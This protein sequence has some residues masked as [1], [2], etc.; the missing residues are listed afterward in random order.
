M[1]EREDF[2][3]RFQEEKPIAMHE[4]L[5]PLAQGYDSVA[6]E[7]DVE[8]GGTDQKF[9]LLVG[10]EL[11]RTY[12]QESQVV[13][14]TPI[15]EGLDGVKKMSKSLGNA[16]GIHE[17]PL[18]M[19]G[20]IMSISDDMMWRYYELLTDV[21]V[22]EIEALKKR[23]H[24][25]ES[26]KDL[27]WKIVRDFHASQAADAAMQDWTRQFQFKQTPDAIPQVEV[28]YEEIASGW[29]PG[30]EILQEAPIKVDKLVYKAGLAASITEASKKRAGRAVKNRRRSC[31]GT[32]L[33]FWV[34]DISE[35]SDPSCRTRA[36][37]GSYSWAVGPL[38]V[39]LSE[40]RISAERSSRAVEGSL[41]RPHYTLAEKAFSPLEQEELPD[42]ACAHAESLGIFRLRVVFASERQHFAQDDNASGQP[43]AAVPT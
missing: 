22:A 29:S 26:K 33:C 3:K 28:N 35:D 6:L 43:R 15:L 31:N 21:Q 17:P 12:G 19:Y 32:R 42:I 8:L 34:P 9:N 36:Q 18:E 25:M 10:R 37:A 2:H 20:K 30:Q 4:L 16:I 39:I 5:Y 14:T 13:L 24:P 11:Q 27:A 41:T 23:Q 7:A 38:N 1:L 40:A